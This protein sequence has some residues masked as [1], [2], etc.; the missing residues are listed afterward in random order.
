[1]KLKELREMCD[2]LHWRFVWRLSHVTGFETLDEGEVVDVT[3]YLASTDKNIDENKDYMKYLS[4]T[5]ANEKIA[6]VKDGIPVFV[7]CGFLNG[8]QPSENWKNYTVIKAKEVRAR[9]IEK[10]AEKYIDKES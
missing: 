8:Q 1:M 9:A 4:W 2:D 6:K 10:V 5:S 3:K 7:M